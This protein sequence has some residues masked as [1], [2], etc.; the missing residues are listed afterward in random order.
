MATVA[1][2]RDSG[3]RSELIRLG[4]AILTEKGFHNFSL[5]ELVALA[6]VPKGSFHYYFS[7]KDAYCLEVIQA[8][9]EYFAKKLDMHLKDTSLSPL[10]R[11]KAFTEDAAIGM[12]RHKFKRGCLVGN[13]SQELAAL[14][15]TFRKALMDVLKDWRGRIRACLEEGKANGEIRADADTA[16]LSRYFWNAWEGAVMCSKLEKSREPLDDASA[17]FLAHLA[18]RDKR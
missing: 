14:D 3:R 8:Y 4:V 2:K 13:L 7:S 1:T 18:P 15:E 5:D 17:A 16:A 10:E 6:G 11:I 9:H 12:Q